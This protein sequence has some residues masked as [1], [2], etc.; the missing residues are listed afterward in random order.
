MNG[1][2]GSLPGVGDAFNSHTYTHIHTYTYRYRYTY[3][4]IP[5]HSHVF[6]HDTII[7]T[8]DV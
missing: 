1:V 3:T 8:C 2:G 4:I 7:I 6:Y 5:T